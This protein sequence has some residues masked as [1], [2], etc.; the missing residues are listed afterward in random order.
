[1]PSFKLAKVTIS[2]LPTWLLVATLTALLSACG[3]GGGGSNSTNSESNPTVSILTGQFLDG[4]VEGLRYETET[5][6]GYTDSQGRF[7]YRS[8]EEVTFY[9]GYI[10][11]GKA[12]ADELITPFDFFPDAQGVD[13]NRVTNLARLLQ[14]FD[15]NAD[16]SDGIQLLDS[17][18]INNSTIQTL[19][20]LESEAGF[21]ASNEVQ[22]LLAEHSISELISANEAQ[23]NFASTLQGI[24]VPSAP[25]SGNNCEG[26]D[27]RCE[28]GTY[29]PIQPEVKGVP[30]YP[31]TSYLG[32]QPSRSYLANKTTMHLPSHPSD[33]L[34]LLAADYPEWFDIKDIAA[35]QS[36]GLVTYYTT[37]P[38][39]HKLSLA[40][41]D[42]KLVGDL[43][44][45]DLN[46]SS[47]LSTEVCGLAAG[48]V[49]TTLAL[50]PGIYTFSAKTYQSQH[51]VEESYASN[52]LCDMN[53]TYRPLKVWSEEIII[54][55]GSCQLIEVNDFNLIAENPPVVPGE[56][57]PEPE[58]GLAAPTLS[59]TRDGGKITLNWNSIEGANGYVLWITDPNNATTNGGF[60]PNVN[61]F[62]VDVTIAG[63][64]SFKVQAFEGTAPEYIDIV[65]GAESNVVEVNIDGSTDDSSLAAPNLSATKE[66]S[67]I[68]L[69]WND[70]EGA[71]GYELFV[72]KT[73]EPD[74][75]G[76]VEVGFGLHTNEYVYEAETEGSYYFLLRAWEWEDASNASDASVTNGPN[77][78]V[79]EV[80]I[81][82]STDDPIL[83][84]CEQP[85]R[86]GGWEGCRNENGNE[87]GLW[88]FYIFDEL[89]ETYTYKDGVR[90]GPYISYD[91]S[92]AE[93][94]TGN[95]VDGLYD[96][97]WRNYQSGKL[98]I[99]N[100]YTNG[101]RN[102][103]SSSS[104]GDGMWVG[105][106]VDDLR[107]GVWSFYYLGT[108]SE[109]V[110]YKNNVK[111]GPYSSYYDDEGWVGNYVD[112]KKEGV[113]DSYSNN[114]FSY[115]I[116]YSNGLQLDCQ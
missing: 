29:R 104:F 85:G 48:A 81:D 64:Y 68:T 84:D 18:R 98:T 40:Y 37:N 65:L 70:I 79:V 110:T 21:E 83:V 112:G 17:I 52:L 77:S 106:Y 94:T 14:S 7:N 39:S 2:D 24:P 49:A 46:Y 114:E 96:G 89:S 51:C 91:D 105:N 22:E 43:K 41:I 71:N 33:S 44:Y 115:S 54:E 76:A 80:D 82:G 66:G 107:D 101:V 36:V 26:S 11:L 8:G 20:F 75:N 108:L 3:G 102:G 103:P 47:P 62:V 25:N 23:Q 19:N 92:G 35:S 9:M 58:P 95:Y 67:K 60:A 74:V 69:T 13:D 63:A 53:Q 73:G 28:P 78:N 42:N 57:D 34:H 27:F 38:G 56:V 72:S 59:A 55:A 6:S 61:E 16:H 1:M 116:C 10:Q 88:S 87:E 5:Q 100:T 109:T 30:L 12:D 111:N 32:Y 97:V 50:E 4:P 86:D 93:Q 90:N 15:K 31:L 45:R 99:M 113:W